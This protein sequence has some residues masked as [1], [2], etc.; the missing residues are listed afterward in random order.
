M[1]ATEFPTKLQV[2]PCCT[3][4]EGCS[5]YGGATTVEPTGWLV[6]LAIA[7]LTDMIDHCYV[8]SSLVDTYVADHVASYADYLW[9]LFVVVYD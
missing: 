7:M 2:F 9:W 8:G 5:A 4:D 3:V 1:S 6:M